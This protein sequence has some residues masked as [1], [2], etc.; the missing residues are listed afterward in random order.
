LRSRTPWGPIS[1]VEETVALGFDGYAI[2]GLSVG[3]PK[4]EM[5][6]VIDH[7]APQLPA[8]RPRYLM[9]VGT[10]SDLVDGVARGLDLF[11][12]VMPTR[13]ARTGWLFTS[14]GRVSIKHARYA[15]DDEPLDPTCGCS[16]CRRFS[17]AYL[18]HLFLGNDPLAVRL[19]TIHNLTFY[20]G[21]MTEMR[22]AI[23]VGEFGRWYER[24]R[25]AVWYQVD[26]ARH[27]KEDAE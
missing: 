5:L 27:D 3:E 22:R 21:L 9:G 18:R 2:G 1:W 26:T 6:R 14:Q 4:E 23:G 17:R 20:L 19:H 12:C 25:N 13:H 8:S 11:D 15:T 24:T 10:P 16:T 7:V